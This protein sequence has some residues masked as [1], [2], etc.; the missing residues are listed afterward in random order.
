MAYDNSVTLLAYRGIGNTIQVPFASISHYLRNSYFLTNLARKGV[1][2][3]GKSWFHSDFYHK[4]GKKILKGNWK[5][6][7]KKKWSWQAG[8]WHAGYNILCSPS[9]FFPLSL[10][11]SLRNP[12]GYNVHGS[13]N[14]VLS[15]FFWVVRV[16][17]WNWFGLPM[18]FVIQQMRYPLILQFLDSEKELYTLWQ[19][20][21]NGKNSKTWATKS[22]E[23]VHLRSP[24]TLILMLCLPL[25]GLTGGRTFH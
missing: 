6:L 19:K 23:L 10:D 15:Y 14:P 5:L 8:L 22:S 4:K 18:V 7:A 1:L 16:C 21:L 25:F 12:L 11:S 24:L 20:L 17:K 9:L 2:L 3:L 13:W